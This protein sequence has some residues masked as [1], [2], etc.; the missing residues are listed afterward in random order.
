M[1][2]VY[3]LQESTSSDESE[4]PES[5][6]DGDDSST[7]RRVNH[8]SRRIRAGK[9]RMSIMTNRVLHHVPRLAENGDYGHGLHLSDVNGASKASASTAK[10]RFF[11]SAARWDDT[12][13]RV[14]VLTEGLAMP[15]VS[16]AELMEAGGRGGEH[17]VSEQ[18]DEMEIDEEEAE[19]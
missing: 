10:R 13:Q 7:S 17:D 14:L 4:D 9:Q 8:S 12:M 19:S 2:F 6:S 11:Q 18:E 15:R 16:V 5:E 3:S 1:R